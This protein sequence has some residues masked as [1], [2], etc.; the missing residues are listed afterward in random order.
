MAARWMVF[1]A[2]TG[3]DVRGFNGKGADECFDFA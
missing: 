2:R 1:R 3:I